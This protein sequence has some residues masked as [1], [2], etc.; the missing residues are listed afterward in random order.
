[1][2]LTDLVILLGSIDGPRLGRLVITY[3]KLGFKQSSEPL[4]FR[5]GQENVYVTLLPGIDQ[6]GSAS[7]TLLLNTYKY[8][9]LSPR[10]TSLPRLER[11]KA[12]FLESDAIKR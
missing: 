12:S 4:V 11:A 9:Q 2:S 5:S 10:R 6:T 8:S 7:N 1:M 3:Y